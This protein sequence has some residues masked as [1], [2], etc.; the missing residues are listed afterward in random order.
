LVTLGG[1]LPTGG[2]PLAG[3]RRNQLAKAV[4]LTTRTL[5]RIRECPAP[6]SSVHSTG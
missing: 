5:V 2:G 1:V 4:A 3:W 6:H